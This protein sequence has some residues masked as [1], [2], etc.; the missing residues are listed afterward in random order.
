[1]ITAKTFMTE[2]AYD[3]YL[4]Y[5]EEKKLDANKALERKIDYELNMFNELI[6][7]ILPYS[8]N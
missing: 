8:R 1:M 5:L 2:E 3:N 4:D 7:T 6:D